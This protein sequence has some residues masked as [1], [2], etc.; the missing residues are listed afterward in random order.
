MSILCFKCKKHTYL[1]LNKTT[2]AFFTH[3]LYSELILS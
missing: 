3:S 2:K 1:L